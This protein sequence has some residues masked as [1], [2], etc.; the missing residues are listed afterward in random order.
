MSAVTE[1]ETR[2]CSECRREKPETEFHWRDKAHTSRVS[3]CKECA[4]RIGTEWRRDHPQDSEAKRH[5]KRAQNF[6]Q[7]GITIEVY[8]EMLGRQ[9]GVCAVCEQPETHTRNGKVRL[10]TV[11]HDH[12]TGRVRGLLCSKCNF[13]I[14]L[15]DD[16]PELLEAAAAYLRTAV[17]ERRELEAQ[18]TDLGGD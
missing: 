3:R 6:R 16:D 9:G 14:G 10:L 8:E 15:C 11:D 12:E 5:H 2:R 18:I 1:S 17:A 7:Y 13:A 4:R